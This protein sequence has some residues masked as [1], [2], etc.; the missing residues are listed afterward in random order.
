M[1]ESARAWE[2]SRAAEQESTARMPYR[3]TAPGNRV[4]VAMSGGVDSSVAAAL[5]VESGYEVI[6]AT[7]KLFC[8]GD[9]VPD[10]PCC[11]LD[12]INDAA[13]VAARLG[14]PHYV[15]D[16]EDRFKVAVIHD[17]VAEYQR[18]RTPIPCVRC[19]TFTKFR[20]LLAHADAMGCD[21]VAT[22]HYAIARDGALHRG[23]DAEKDQTYFLWGI[24]RDVVHRLLTPLGEM[25]KREAREI[26]RRLG[27][28]TADKAESVEICFV[29]DDDYVKVLEQYLPSNDPALS[30]GPIKNSMG[31]KIGEHSGY[32]RYTIGQRRRLPGGSP[33]PLYVVAIVP[34]ERAVVV[35]TADELFGHQVTLSEV[36]WL[37]DPLLPGDT[38]GIQLRYRASAVPARVTEDSAADPGQLRLDLLKPVRAITPGQSGV[39]YQGTRMLGGG[40]I[41]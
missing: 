9:N 39:L 3:Q 37:A 1:N 11:S 17:F 31:E 26:A 25:T 8:Y 7:M 13:S 32:A 18:G 34:E 40:V 5:L 19:N 20:D 6:G 22:G 10:R 21:F 27:L 12:S 16:L 4:L 24:D 28:V 29:P 35:G 14:V 36:N 38:C 15:F 23:N 30:P 2:G 33:G 41:N